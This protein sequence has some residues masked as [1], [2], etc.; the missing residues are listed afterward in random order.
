MDAAIMMVYEGRVRPEDIQYPDWVEAQWRKIERALDAIEERWMS[1]LAG[2]LDASQ[3]AVGCALAY[4][5]F[6]LGARNWR[7]GRPAL[8]EWEAAFA[9]R[10]SMAA[11]MPANP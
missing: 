10:E 6:R 2:P 5:D 1:H 11:S 8:A 4:L 7:E 9:K 3:I